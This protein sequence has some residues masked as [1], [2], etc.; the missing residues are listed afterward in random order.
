MT[1]QPLPLSGTQAIAFHQAMEDRSAYIG[2]QPWQARMRAGFE[3]S[4]PLPGCPHCWRD[5]QSIQWHVFAHEMWT[6]VEPCGHWFTTEMPIMV[7][8]S[9]DGWH[10]YVPW[11]P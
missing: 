6:I 1:E 4:V 5:A 3:E 2:E 11:L 7:M 9:G 10:S 8:R